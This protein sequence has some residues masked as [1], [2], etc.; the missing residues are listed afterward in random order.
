MIVVVLAGEVIIELSLHMCVDRKLRKLPH[1][2]LG[3]STSVGTSV[4]S[5]SEATSCVSMASVAESAVND[6]GVSSA[7]SESCETD[8]L[9]ETRNGLEKLEANAGSSV[10]ETSD[11]PDKP[12]KL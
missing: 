5:T 2:N 3:K 12:G 7:V 9:A 8:V 10:K 6:S 11:V 1:S 4:Q